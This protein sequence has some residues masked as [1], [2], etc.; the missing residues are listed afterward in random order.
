V[1][2]CIYHGGPSMDNGTGVTMTGGG[3]SGCDN[4]ANQESNMTENVSRIARCAHARRMQSFE[5]AEMG[6]GTRRMGATGCDS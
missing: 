1:G 2:A 3:L 4:F 6:R 5:A